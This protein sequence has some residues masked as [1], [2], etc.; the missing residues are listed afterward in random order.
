[1]D[2][3]VRPDLGSQVDLA[4]SSAIAQFQHERWHWSKRSDYTIDTTTG[5]DVYELDSR[6]AALIG[7]RYVNGDQG[8]RLVPMTWD[9]YRDR[10]T[11]A[12]QTGTPVNY[13]IYGDFLHVWPAPDAEAQIVLDYWRNWPE[14][15]SDDDADNDW[16]NEAEALIRWTAKAMLCQDVIGDQANA[17]VFDGLAQRE[18][19]RLRKKHARRIGAD[20]ATVQPYDYCS[21]PGPRDRYRC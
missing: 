20:T 8:T 4:I 17:S 1:M 19:L 13:V 7:A 10:T 9:Y 18:R 5:T 2:E 16:M 21:A 12:V 15:T 14:P 11:N 6:V 3:L